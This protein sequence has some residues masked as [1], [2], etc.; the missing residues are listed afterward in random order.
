MTH[1]LHALVAL[2][3]AL[4]AGCGVGQ[5]PAP[6]VSKASLSPP[7]QEY[8]P[9]SPTQPPAPSP[10]PVASP[11]PSPS[12][13]ATPAVG[14]AHTTD[15]PPIR[16][17]GGVRHTLLPVA[18]TL[19]AVRRVCILSFLCSEVA[20]VGTSFTMADG[21]RVDASA[22]LPTVTL[23]EYTRVELLITPD[24]KD[25]EAAD[26]IDILDKQAELE[27]R[28]AAR[29]VCRIVG[30]WPVCP[31]TM[32]LTSIWAP[33]PYMLRLNYTKAGLT[34]TLDFTASR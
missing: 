25:N 33:R 34:R 15:L 12:S 20:S 5:M 32:D 8:E 16:P 19:R 31:I 13:T 26:S 6:K 18:V 9:L 30:G 28:V 11:A 27:D 10:T 7:D 22:K 23:D 24:A 14:G 2:L 4:W 29:G 17:S 3:A 1:K 21:D